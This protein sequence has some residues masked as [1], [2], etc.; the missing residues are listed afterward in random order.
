MRIGEATEFDLNVVLSLGFLGPGLCKCTHDSKHP[1]YGSIYSEASFD[2]MFHPKHPRYSDYKQFERFMKYESSHYYIQPSLVLH[3]FEGVITKALNVLDGHNC[4][5]GE[6]IIIRRSKSGPAHT[7]KVTSSCGLNID[8]GLVPVFRFGDTNFV[9]KELTVKPLLWRLSYPILERSI[10]HNQHCAKNV[11]KLLKRF[12]DVQGAPWKL[13]SSYYIKTLVMLELEVQPWKNFGNFFLHTLKK[14]KEYLT[15]RK[16]PSYFDRE[17]N[18]L[19]NV[20]IVTIDNMRN[21]LNRILRDIDTN[22]PDTLRK[23]FVTEDCVDQANENYIKIEIPENV[24]LIL[25]LY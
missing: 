16:I 25:L 12:R 1:G 19:S 20:P 6:Y 13:L 2:K 5:A 8:I 22:S 18:L 3:W 4:I 11:I 7:L 9:P 24:I 23:Y 15:Q 10:L 17:C 21:R 14:L